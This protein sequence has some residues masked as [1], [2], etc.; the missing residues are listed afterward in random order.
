V[1]ERA[2]FEAKLQDIHSFLDPKLLTPEQ[3]KALESRPR[4]RV[5]AQGAALYDVLGFQNGDMYVR[6]SAGPIWKTTSQ[7][8]AQAIVSADSR[9]R[10][11]LEAL[12]RLP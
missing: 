8:D 4:G 9:A 3:V 6:S 10:D 2:Q 1:T 11:L 12:E 5:L 7:A